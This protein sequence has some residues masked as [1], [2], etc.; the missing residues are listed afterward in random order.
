M[1]KVP[2]KDNETT[3]YEQ[4]EKRRTTLSYLRTWGCLAK[5]NVSIPKKR[6]LGSKTVD[7]VNFGY[8]TNSVGY[9]FLVVKY[10]VPDVM[11]GTIIE[12]KDATF[13]EDIFPMKDMPSTSRQESEETPEPTIS[14]EYYEQT[15]DEKS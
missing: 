1:N 7:C 5:V 11:V 12:S 8:A 9:R 10:E 2:T 3:P 13:F 4:W 6:K 15:P 14:M